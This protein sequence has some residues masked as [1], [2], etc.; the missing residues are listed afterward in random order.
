MGL[1]PRIPKVQDTLSPWGVL[2]RDMIP[3]E[4]FMGAGN[5]E[6]EPD[7]QLNEDDPVFIFYTS[8]TTGVPKGALYTQGRA[9]DDTRRFPAALCVAQG[10]K[11]V[12]IMPLVSCGRGQESVGVFFCGGSQ[13]HHAAN[14]L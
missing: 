13:H 8:G 10:D 2:L 11:Q 5:P 7:V 6:D 1:R 3:F 4:D 9:M 12:Q 14:I